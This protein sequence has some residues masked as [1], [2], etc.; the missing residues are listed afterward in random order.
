[1][2][3]RDY[4]AAEEFCSPKYIQHTAH[5][6]RGREGLFDLIKSIPPTLKYEPGVI[7]A[8]GNFVTPLGRT[9][10]SCPIE[11]ITRSE[12]E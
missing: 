3:K 5:I 8:D 2:K 7:V 11:K 1:M 10:K 6:A 4:A 12:H 9:L